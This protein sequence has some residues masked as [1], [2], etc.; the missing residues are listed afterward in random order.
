[1]ILS[2]SDV[3]RNTCW[4]RLKTG[5]ELGPLTSEA[6]KKESNAIERNGEKR[7]EKSHFRLAESCS[8]GGAAPLS[9]TVHGEPG[10]SSTPHL[11]SNDCTERY[12]IGKLSA[13]IAAL[14]TIGPSAQLISLAA[15]TDVY[16]CFR[17]GS[18]ALSSDS[19]VEQT[20]LGVGGFEEE[21]AAL[22]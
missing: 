12:R 3:P 14:M 20:V 11:L 19:E 10:R 15:R 8:S 13:Q 22:A 16:S 5:D 18:A 7:P 6:A 2:N 17:R 21:A 9:L 1:L 4:P